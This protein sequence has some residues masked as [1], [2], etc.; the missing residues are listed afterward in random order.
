MERRPLFSTLVT[1]RTFLAA[2]ATLAGARARLAA[3]GQGGLEQFAVGGLECNDTTKPTP[4]IRPDGTFKPGAPRR[5]S[6]LETGVSG[7]RLELTGTLAGL[8]CGPIK[9]AVLDFWHAD[10]SGAYDVSGYRFRG[11]Q[12]TDAAGRFRLTTTMPGAS[13]GRARHLSVRV[14]LMKANTPT[15]VLWTELFF[16]DDPRNT[17]DQRY[18][19]ELT[20]VARAD[21]A[22]FDI[23]LNM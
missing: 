16:A 19:P 22:T 12:V 2:A 20:M 18:R 4:A 13:G 15:P 6:L 21:G 9:D 10:A 3:A 7:P 5:T 1:R 23:R 14:A 17:R 11:S 8:K